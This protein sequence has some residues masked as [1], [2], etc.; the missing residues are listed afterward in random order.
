MAAFLV[1]EGPGND[2]LRKTHKLYNIEQNE[3]NLI[4]K[5]R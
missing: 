3:K 2:Q 4:E 1:P 5:K